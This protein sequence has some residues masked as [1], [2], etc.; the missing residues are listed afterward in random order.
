MD[1]SACTVPEPVADLI[2]GFYL[3][4]A[5][6]LGRRTAELHRA[7]AVGG[8]DPAWKAE[9]YSIIHQRAVYQSM[10]NQARRTLQLLAQ[11][12]NLLPT[13]D[14]EAADRILAAEEEIL[15]RLALIV[16]R[17]I[18]TMKIRIHGNFHLGKVLFTGKDFVVI[19]F[20]GEPDR[21]LSERRIK[22]SPLRDVAAMIRS[23]HNATLTALAQHGNGHP[24]DAELLEPWADACYYH[25]SCRYLAGYL[26]RMGDSPLI[27]TNRSELETILLL[28]LLDK[29]VNDLGYALANRPERASL[30][31][32][33]IETV[34]REY[35]E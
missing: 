1:G 12:R 17:R 14:L 35:R 23:F 9:E 7:L 27:P 5:G 10:R 6:L 4:M 33:G 31:L 30:H 28:F 32:R 16:G 2:G 19:D 25:V 22:R 34:L 24:G 20:E 15:S 8:N 13:S 26:E 29:A 21:A 11:N 18:G 3:E